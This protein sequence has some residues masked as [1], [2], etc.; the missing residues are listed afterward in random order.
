[1][2]KITG[3]TFALQQVGIAQLAHDAAVAINIG[4]GVF[5]NITA[6]NR[7]KTRWVDVTKVIHKSNALAVIDSDW[8]TGG[9]ILATSDV[10]SGG[11]LLGA[12]SIKWL[13]CGG[14]MSN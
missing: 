11:L 12:H 1:M 14:L 4:K 3:T 10:G 6:L 9:A 2:S 7:Q 13:P 5:A 8:G